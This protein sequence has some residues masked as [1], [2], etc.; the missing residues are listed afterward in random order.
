MDVSSRLSG[1]EWQ[2][3]ANQLLASHYGPADYQ[4]VPDNHKG[5]AGLEGFTLRDGHAYQAYG[6]EEPVDTKTR[7]EKQRDK[8]TT[9]VGKFIRNR[10]TLTHILG[11]VRITRWILLVPYFDS[12]DIV[13]HATKKRT[14]VL[15]A[16][17]PYVDASLFSIAI[18]AESSFREECDRL[19]SQREDSVAIKV[20]LATEE[21]V[22]DWA[23]KNDQL[24]TR[25]EIKLARI[26]TL[27][28]S[29]QR[30][31]FRNHVLAWFLEGQQLLSE[32]KTY[33]L[34]FEGA[35]KAKL[36]Q[37]NYLALA[38]IQRAE[39]QEV[40]QRAVDSLRES[41]RSAV[42]SLSKMSAQTLAHEAVADW[43]LRCPLDFCNDG[44]S[45]NV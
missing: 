40:L 19:L 21:E 37:E 38:M 14:E 25:L 27:T 32:L 13:A 12:K 22:G 4:V 45:A 28:S 43:L 23:S 2:D 16:N 31:R 18:V 42:G 44:I 5:D 29:E 3:W 7:Y 15:A 39:P 20:N 9:D 6:L 11:S 26:P 41:L 33:P 30:V 36:H 24:V 10:E 8:L 1:E 35:T 34:L 17:L